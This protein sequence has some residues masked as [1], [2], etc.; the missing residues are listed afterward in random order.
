MITPA[1]VAATP[2]RRRLWPWV[3]GALCTPF[4]LLGAA[5]F[6]FLTLNSDASTLRRNVMAA[7]NADWDTRIQF[8][9]GSLSFGALRT[10]LALVPGCD[11]DARLALGVVRHVSVGVY[12]LADRSSNWSREQLFT[13]TDKAMHRRGWSRLVGVSHHGETVLVYATEAA[14]LEGSFEVCLAVVDGRQLVVAAASMD[15]AT[16]AKL[17]KAHKDGGFRAGKRHFRL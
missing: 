16:L 2:A 9:V 17:V 10:C 6:S 11:D 14:N 13:E 7:T 3:V 12:E 8:S 15:G 5:A 4:V 1:P